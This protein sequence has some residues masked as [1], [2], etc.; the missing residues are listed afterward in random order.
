MQTPLRLNVGA[1]IGIFGIIYPLARLIVTQDQLELNATLFGNAV[2]SPSDVNSVKSADSSIFW[3]NAFKIEHNVVG[4]PKDIQFFS[5]QKPAKVMEELKATGFIE[6]FKSDESSKNKDTISRQADGLFP[7]KR[8]VAIG[9]LCFLIAFFVYDFYKFATITEMYS[10]FGIG[11]FSALSL[12][13]FGLVMSLISCNFRKLILKKGRKLKDIDR[14]VF[15][16]LVM[17]ITVILSNLY[18]GNFYFLR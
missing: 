14:S 15:L 9:T 4:Y 16:L 2:F 18:M 11:V 17:V 12:L 3:G 6:N 13:A 8:N 1:R 5:Y 10:P 7:L